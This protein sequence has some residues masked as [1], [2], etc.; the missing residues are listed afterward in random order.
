MSKSNS[1][2]TNFAD[3]IAPI[4]EA[5]FFRDYYG[6]KPLHIKGSDAKTKALPDW[7]GLA[8]LVNQR[9]IWSAKSLNLV[10]D[11]KPLSP[12]QYCEPALNNNQQQVMRPIPERVQYWLAQ[13]ASLV[14]NDIDTL[15]HG[16]NIMANALEQALN[17][18]VQANLYASSRARQAFNS[19]FDTHDVFAVHV[20]GEKRWKLYETRMDHPISHPRHG[21]TAYSEAEHVKQRGKVTE[22]VIMQPGDVLYIPR[23]VY[24]DALATDQEDQGAIHIAF[25]ATYPIGLEVMQMLS[26]VLV[27]NPLFRQ[28]VPLAREGE[29]AFNKHLATLGEHVA[30]LMADPAL[31]K[32]LADWQRAYAYPRG[33]IEL[34]VRPNVTSYQLAKGFTIASH[35]GQPVLKGEKG[36]I[37]IPANRLPFVEFIVQHKNID[38]FQ[39]MDHFAHVPTNECD[40]ALQ[41]LAQMGMLIIKNQGN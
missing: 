18:K 30:K 2:P 1:T 20:A 28:N 3:L 10:L 36:A 34:P 37:P 40:Q 16:L 25:G 8:A 26:D 41:E 38:R 24:H 17:A 22:E 19:H 9:A 7:N 6:K 12:D 21:H 35:Q 39:F 29:A 23:G 4:K 14:A 15:T 27:D 13:G 33:T 5:D 32:R 31:A 11:R